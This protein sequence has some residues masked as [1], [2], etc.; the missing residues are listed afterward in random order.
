MLCKAKVFKTAS[1]IFGL[2]VG[3]M[4]GDVLCFSDVH[5]VIHSVIRVIL[6]LIASVCGTAMLVTHEK[7]GKKGNK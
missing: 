2:T 5:S 4:V 3:V 1:V 6:T 7:H